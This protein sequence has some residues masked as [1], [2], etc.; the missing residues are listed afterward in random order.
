MNVGE[1]ATTKKQGKT[2]MGSLSLEECIVAAPV[3]TT[4]IC[5]PS[6]ICDKF[7]ARVVGTTHEALDLITVISLPTY[8]FRFICNNKPLSYLLCAH[9]ISASGMIQICIAYRNVAAELMK[10][11]PD[12]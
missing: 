7:M 11:T 9:T 12:Y 1:R 2:G 8:R 5:I 4:S 3:I 10:R 6:P